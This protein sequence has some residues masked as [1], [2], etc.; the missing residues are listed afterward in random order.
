MPIQ[1]IQDLMDGPRASLPPLDSSDSLP[2][3]NIIIPLSPPGSMQYQQFDYNT[4]PPSP[5]FSPYPF[6]FPRVEG[7]DATRDAPRR[8][9]PLLRQ[10]AIQNLP[11]L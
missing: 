3:N 11:C 5:S 7:I 10:N 9:P 6:S 4:F 8:P 1:T 2:W